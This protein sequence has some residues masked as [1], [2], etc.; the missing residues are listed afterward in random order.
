[1]TLGGFV[2]PFVVPPVN[3]ALLALVAQL[4][5]WRRLAGLAVAALLLL[6]VP[7]VADALLGT[8]ERGQGA[9][10][11]AGAQAIV[12]LGA[13][14]VRLADGST[15]PGPLSL[16]RLRTAAAL[17][18]RTGLPL[19]VSGGVTQPGA[20]PVAVAMADSLRADFQVPARWIED[21]SADTFENARDSAALLAAAGVAT[22]LVVTDQWHMRR[23]L[24]AFRTTGLR[25]IPAPVPPQ[26]ASGAQVEDLVPRASAWLRSYYA[27][28]E[29]IGIG[30]Y[31]LRVGL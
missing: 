18:R 21:R 23:A 7:L 3:L 20:A 8:L 15:V 10:D 28:H 19:L 12:V 11:P 14:V 5:G 25:A 1:M 9:G 2:T 26:A 27:L 13:E 4:A 22:L 30:W 16:E 17:A 31:E 6:A 24:L 29:W